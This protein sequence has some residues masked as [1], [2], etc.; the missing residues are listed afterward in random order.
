MSLFPRRTR[1]RRLAA[2]AIAVVLGTTGSG[3][4]LGTQTAAAQQAQPRAAVDTAASGKRAALADCPPSP[5]WANTGGVDR[6]LLQYDIEGNVL[7]HVSVAR[8]YGD[9]AFSADGTK[10]YAVDFPGVGSTSLYTLDPVTGAEIDSV[11]ITGPIGD[12]AF[13]GQAAVNG[14]TARADGMLIAGSFSTSRIFLIDP[15]TGASTE[16]PYAF[17]DGFLSAGDFLTLEDGDVLAFATTDNQL[18]TPSTVFRIHPDNTITR[19][20]TVPKMFGGAVSGGA[21]YAFGA[22]GDI[23]RLDDLPTEESTDPLPVTVVEATGNSFYGATAVQDAGQ[24][25][26]PAYT[27]EKSASTPGPVGAGDTVTYT[28]TVVNTGEIAANAAFSDDLTEILDDATV[29]P[30][31]VN[32]STGTAELNG[33]TLTWSGLLGTTQSATV[34]YAVEVNSPLSGDRDLGNTVTPTA[35]GGTCTAA[36]RCAVNVPVAATEPKLRIRKD[37]EETAFTGPGEILHYTFEVTN[38]GPVTVSDIEV[39]DDG[40]GTPK[41]TCP[42]T[43][44]EPGDSLTC[45]ATYKTTPADVKA[46]RITNTAT[47]TGRGPD[48]APVTA[49]SNRVTLVACPCTTDCAHVKQYKV[50][51]TS[52]QPLH[53]RK[54]PGTDHKI[55]GK[56]QPHTFVAVTCRTNGQSV[57]GNRTWYRLADGRGWIPGRFTAT[58]EN[59]PGCS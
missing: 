45:T 37:V 31:S 11:P 55:T 51:V 47:V 12:L 22:A 20:G 44:L 1:R 53:I 8:D 54:G 25:P 10:L 19:I 2:A 15:E 6:E 9:I 16:A 28:V 48:G 39:T 33:S 30:G 36:G 32:A 40:P 21:V 57:D 5:L 42:D 17:P 46:G 38:T 27:V 7:T 35:P 58:K 43:T 4:L 29:V 23:Y 18:T 13:F 26:E 14:L 49:T 56:L 50:K 59:I 41:V 24:C 52:R 34:T 3:V